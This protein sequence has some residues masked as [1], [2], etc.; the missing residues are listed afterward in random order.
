MMS[1]AELSLWIG[2][3]Y[4]ALHA[5]LV[6]APQ[7]VRKLF[8][9]FPRNFWLGAVL[10]AMA[11]GWSAVEV[12]AMPLGNFIGD[13]KWLLWILTPVVLGLILVFMNELLAARALGGLLLLVANPVLS[14]QCLSA[15]KATWLI[16]GLAYCWVV[17][18]TL[19][20]LSPYRFRLAVEKFCATDGSCRLA[21]A[22]GVVLG[23][24][25]VVL[26]LTV[27]ARVT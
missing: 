13:Y 5:P 17:A 1:L 26:G 10:S 8:K 22:A 21:G 7:T 14:I 12:N 2:G 15:S 9:L 19:L 20:V 6:L 24:V 4:V 16:A 27:F 23:F 25:L 18:G 11:L 3:V